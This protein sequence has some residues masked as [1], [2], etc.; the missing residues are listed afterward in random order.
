[1]MRLFG[2]RM[3]VEID[4]VYRFDMERQKSCGVGRLLI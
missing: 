3:L 2:I 1:M 4:P